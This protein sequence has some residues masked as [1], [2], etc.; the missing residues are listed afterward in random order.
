MSE[1]RPA[2]SAALAGMFLLAALITCAA[3][4]LGIGWLAGSPTVG[5]I[6]GAMVGIP[7]SFYL[8]YRQ[9]RDI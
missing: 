9:Y 1:Q 3:A 2:A 7:L 8:V 4:G 5:V 6:A